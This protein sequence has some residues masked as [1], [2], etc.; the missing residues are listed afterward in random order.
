MF[1][2]TSFLF[3]FYFVVFT[4]FLV[5]Q[6]ILF[7][8]FVIFIYIFYLSVY[9]IMI[10]SFLFF[11][12]QAEDGIRDTSVTGV[13]DV[14]SSD[15]FDHRQTISFA[16]APGR[17]SRQ[18]TQHVG[19]STTFSRTED[20]PAGR[21]QQAGPEGDRQLESQP[22]RTTRHHRSHRTGLLHRDGELDHRHLSPRRPLILEVQL[23][24]DLAG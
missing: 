11:F 2:D 23:L 16:P 7:I 18:G 24:S 20:L 8:P 22:R 19:C 12:F 5:E 4:I 13:Q 15:L 10:S 21:P 14:C 17:I 6:S 3:W 1:Y 9:Y